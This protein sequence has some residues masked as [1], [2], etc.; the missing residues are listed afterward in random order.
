MALCGAGQHLGRNH[1]QVGRRLRRLSAEAGQA[2]SGG[3][4]D[5]PVSQS[6]AS[7]SIRQSSDPESGAL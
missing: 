6:G 1:G 2:H 4:A 5:R 7:Q 3:K